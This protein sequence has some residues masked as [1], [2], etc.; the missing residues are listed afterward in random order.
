MAAPLV[1]VLLPVFNGE[2]Y[3]R[4]AVKSVLLQDCADFELILIDDG[5]TDGSLEILRRFEEADP[6]VR[7]ITRENR[8]LIATLNEGLALARG[9]L[10]A[11]MDA[12]DIC[13]PS[14]LSRQV[15]ILRDNPELA[16][17]ACEYDAIIRSNRIH[18]RAP[19]LYE[20][21]CD[22]AGRSLFY[23]VFA[24]PT[25]MFNRQVLGSELYYD[26]NY[27][28]AE[29][30]DLF[31]R[32]TGRFQTHLITDSLLAYRL[33]PESISSKNLKDTRRMHMRIVRENCE[34]RGFACAADMRRLFDVDEKDRVELSIRILKTLIADIAG[35]EQLLKNG[36][37]AGAVGLFH[38]IRFMLR[39]EIGPRAMND[40]IE[41]VGW[42]RFVRRR[43]RYALAFPG[44]AGLLY[45][46]VRFTDEFEG[47][48]RNPPL[49]RVI[50]LYS[51]IVR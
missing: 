46:G 45:A 32:I 11:R 24:H 15:A 25:V 27:V 39:D 29:D 28:L 4:A 2:R 51:E 41:G 18:R 34:A 30:F 44:V 1:S 14:R 5:S 35:A 8:G 22:L 9:N 40:F 42:W 6:R 49:D 10:I 26:A 17:C 3:V 37:D 13:Y 20:N 36:L 33:H 47:W 21:P 31:R 48:A 43:E 19:L 12:D 16:L 50:P 23:T 38:F 7:L